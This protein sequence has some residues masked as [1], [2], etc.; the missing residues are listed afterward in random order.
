MSV[1]EVPQKSQ[2]LVAPVV[3]GVFGSMAL[4]MVIIRIWQRTMF[5]P[6]FGW[7]DGLIVAALLCSGPLNVMMFPSMFIP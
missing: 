4:A 1:C 2:D 3:A 5:K 7:D 6:G